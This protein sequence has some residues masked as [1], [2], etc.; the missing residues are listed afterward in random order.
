MEQPRSKAALI[1][2]KSILRQ[3]T[4]APKSEEKLESECWKIHKR[5]KAYRP[6]KKLLYIEDYLAPDQNFQNQE[7]AVP[8]KLKKTRQSKAELLQPQNSVC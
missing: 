7:E 2:W 5:K 4:K 8:T 6:K 1:F 3:N